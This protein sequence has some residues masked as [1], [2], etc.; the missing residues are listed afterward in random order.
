MVHDWNKCSISLL[1][2]LKNKDDSHFPNHRKE[3]ER[4][5][6]RRKNLHFFKIFFYFC[7]LF[8]FLFLRVGREGSWVASNLL[9]CVYMLT[10][11]FH[12]VLLMSLEMLPLLSTPHLQKSVTWEVIQKYLST[13]P[14][15]ECYLVKTTPWLLDKRRL[16]IKAIMNV[17]LKMI[18]AKLTLPSGSMSQVNSRL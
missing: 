1:Q 4:W 18:M 3:E 6:S 17:L 14:R 12:P 11:Q 5:L 13:G 9:I 15:M 16:K 7:Y 2:R 10:L 8:Y